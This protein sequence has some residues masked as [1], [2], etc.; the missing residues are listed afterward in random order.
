MRISRTNLL[1]LGLVI[2][3]FAM[4][5]ALYSKLP[6][7]VPTHWNA[8]GVV[9]GFMP[10]P[11]GPF[12]LPLVMLG[13]YLLLMVI[14]RISPRGYRVERFQSVFEIIQATIGSSTD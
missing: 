1:S 8:R 9:D 10:K 14:P 11:W 2:V 12:I 3:S 5:A 6:Q 13:V 4:T 7:L